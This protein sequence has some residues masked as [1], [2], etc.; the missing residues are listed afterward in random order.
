MTKPTP[1][2][3]QNL[4][5][6]SDYLRNLPEDYGQFSMDN[7]ANNDANPDEVDTNECGT[8]A[9]A[10]GHGPAAGLKPEPGMDWDDYEQKMF[11]VGL[12]RE[13]DLHQAWVYMFG[14]NHPDDATEA[15]DRIQTYLKN[16]CEVPDGY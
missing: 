16:D 15:A 4:A 13:D 2:Q 9:C 12:M 10:V 8:I 11:G 6:L 7:Y 14:P 5:V 3:R 1:Q